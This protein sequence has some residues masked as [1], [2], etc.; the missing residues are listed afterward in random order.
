M[1][2]A[3]RDSDQQFHMSGEIAD[4]CSWLLGHPVQ[5]IPQITAKAGRPWEPR[6]S[7]QSASQA[8]MGVGLSAK[9]AASQNLSTTSAG[10]NCES[11]ANHT[12]SKTMRPEF[13]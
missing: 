6:G 2:R 9:A 4:R 3:R 7:M 13:Q 1:V 5:T 11:N 10:E 8:Q 12:Y